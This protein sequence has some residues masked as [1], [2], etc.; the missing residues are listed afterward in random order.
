[1]TRL[2]KEPKWIPISEKFPEPNKD[3]LL[4]MCVNSTLKGIN[5][6][7]IGVR[8]GYYYELHDCWIVKDVRFSN[9]NIIAWMPLPEPYE[10]ERDKE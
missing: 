1:M 5:K 9:D 10:T 7:F 4:T 3:V 6:N 2:E 8:C